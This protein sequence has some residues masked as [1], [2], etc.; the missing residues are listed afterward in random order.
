[1]DILFDSAI[2]IP[3]PL[4]SSAQPAGMTVTTNGWTVGSN[5]LNTG[6]GTLKTLRV[7]AFSNDGVTPLSGSGVLFNTRFVR[8]S[9]TAGQNTPLSWSP[10]PNDFELIDTDLNAF[11][12]VQ[13]N[14]L[15]TITGPTPTP[16]PTG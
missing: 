16:G 13:N 10:F 6:P 1:A 14:G 11:S 4:G 8:V 2:A 3:S 12:P 15:I 7:S 5:V 9:T